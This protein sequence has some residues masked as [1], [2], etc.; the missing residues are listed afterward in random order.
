MADILAMDWGGRAGAC[1]DICKCEPC[2]GDPCN[3]YDCCR[4]CVCWCCPIL[5]CM[6]AV[7]L[8]AAAMDQDCALVN[9]CFPF[10]IDYYFSVPF[11]TIT[12]RH[13]LR[14]K[15]GA[16][17]PP[18]DVGGIVGDAICIICCFHCSTCQMLRSVDR[19][20]WDWLGHLRQKGLKTMVEP[21]IICRNN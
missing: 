14:T 10:A 2:C 19:D 21:I 18:F 16:G 9:H 8:Y 6:S 3:C 11:A 17:R 1:W 4:C 12:M 7:K 13:N 20:A 15:Y 5:G